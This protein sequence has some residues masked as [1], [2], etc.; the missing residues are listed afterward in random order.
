MERRTAKRD[1]Q[2]GFGLVELMIA[3]TLGLF[4]SAAVIQVFVASN[5]SSRLQDSLAMVQENARFAM[6]LL[7]EEVRM[8]GYMGCTSVGAVTVQNIAV[9]SNEVDFGPRTVYVGQDNLSGGNALGALAG[10]DAMQIK[11]ASEEFIRINSATLPAADKLNVADNTLG[12]TKGDY[13]MVADCLNANVFRVSNTPV[14]AGNGASSF[15]HASGT[16]NSSGSLSKLYGPDAEIFAFETINYFVRD[17]GRDTPAGNPI[18]A[19]FFQQRVAG[20]G[21]TMSAATEL[22]EG[23]EDM[24]L[25]YGVDTNDDRAVDEYRSGAAITAAQWEDVLSVRISLQMVG[26]EENVVGKSGSADAQT[27]MDSSGTVIAN[28]DGRFRQVFTNVF[29]IRNKLP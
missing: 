9:P 4:L 29:A 23:V 1:I 6:R 22:V 19:L 16:Y 5:S 20:S 3:I 14:A 12:L 15:E 8:S 17:T 18:Y 26:P 24:Q 21:G 2:S 28:N 25:T 7:G 11:K 10:T 13:V 27:V